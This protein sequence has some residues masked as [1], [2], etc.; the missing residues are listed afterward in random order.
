MPRARSAWFPGA[1]VQAIQQWEDLS[2]LIPVRG[3][4]ACGH[5]HPGGLREGLEEDACAVAAKAPPSPPPV[6]GGTRAI[7]GARR[8]LA[9]PALLGQPEH[10]RGHG[11]QCAS[12]VP[13][14]QPPMGGALGRP[15]R[16]A[17]EVTPAATRTQNGAPRI[18]P[19]APGGRGPAA[20]PCRR[21]RR[22]HLG[23]ELPRQVG[24]PFTRA[25]HGTLLQQWPGR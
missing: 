7:H 11:D 2:P 6:P 17:G 19:L 12:S 25:S 24:S 15:L 1:D 22:Q 4:G 20:T 14:L 3:R 16:P 23:K 10:A 5:R 9:E 21:Q 13:A 8:P 18:H